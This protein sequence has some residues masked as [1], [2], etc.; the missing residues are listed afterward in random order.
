MCVKV[1]LGSII[2]FLLL[3]VSYIRKLC[4]TLATVS[5]QIQI[6]RSLKKLAHISKLFFT[7][8]LE[9]VALIALAP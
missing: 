6:E 7:P 1:I 2:W 5:K 9:T 4:I 3:A 8:A